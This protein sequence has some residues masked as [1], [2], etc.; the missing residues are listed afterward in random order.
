MLRR[1]QYRV[2]GLA[3]IHRLVALADVPD[4]E[5]VPHAFKGKPAVLFR[6]GP[7]FAFQLISLWLV[8]WTVKLG[9]LPSMSLL[10]KWLLPLQ[11]ISAGL[12]SDRSAMAIELKG[13]A[14]GAGVIRRWTLIAE[15]GDGPEIPTMAA[16]L[17]ARAVAEGRFEPGTPP[18]CFPLANSSRS[19]SG[20]P[21]PRISRQVPMSRFTGG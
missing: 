11:K 17:F 12:G 6:A 10:A 5:I 2:R 3:P 9:W 1:E 18:V 13:M 14:Q 16:Q 8:S 4:H 21:F 20:F 15:S 19:S 7:E